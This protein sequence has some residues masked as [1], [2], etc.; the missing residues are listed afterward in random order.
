MTVGWRPRSIGACTL[1]CA[2]SLGAATA[3]SAPVVPPGELLGVEL[4]TPLKPGYDLFDT[5]AYGG[6]SNGSRDGLDIP[7]FLASLPSTVLGARVEPFISELDRIGT[8]SGANDGRR[9]RNGPRRLGDD[10]T[11]ALLAVSDSTLGLV[12]PKA[13]FDAWRRSPAAVVLPL[14]LQE[15]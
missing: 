15:T 2:C 7:I 5:A 8:G 4:G 13:L 14:S 3:F 12:S 10:G 9:I 11:T 6:T 1:A